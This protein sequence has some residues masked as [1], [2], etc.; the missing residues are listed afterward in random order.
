MKERIA[1]VKRALT[2]IL[3]SALAVTLVAC[4]T[5]DSTP[6]GTD[7]ETAVTTTAPPL[8]TNQD[9]TNYSL[10]EAFAIWREVELPII[11]A[12]W[13]AFNHQQARPELNVDYP[14][15]SPFESTSQLKVFD[16]V[17][18]FTDDLT[19]TSVFIDEWKLNQGYE[20]EHSGDRYTLTWDSGFNGNK[21][22]LECIWTGFDNVTTCT[23][24]DPHLSD[25]D[26]EDRAVLE[27]VRTPY[28]YAGSYFRQ[29]Y[30]APAGLVRIT[31][32]EENGIIGTLS[33]PAALEAGGLSQDTS[34][35]SP[36]KL[37][38]WYRMEGNNCTGQN[39]NGTTFDFDFTR[40]P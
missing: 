24:V 21:S 28:G 15:M 40:R 7:D 32:S 29:V 37:E 27:F 20:Y 10:V 19:D 25:P 12:L 30:N 5:E 35:E 11:K 31:V 36:M 34:Y 13:S 1:I 2:F 23:Y 18:L 17:A 22:K 6:G 14:A 33:G 26:L 9:T 39:Q 4:G 3:T 16:A 8:G 38:T